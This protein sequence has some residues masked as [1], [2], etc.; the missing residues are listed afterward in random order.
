[1]RSILQ[2]K[3]L[4][5]DTSMDK[6]YKV[7]TVDSED[8]IIQRDIDG[9]EI[10]YEPGDWAYIEYS[11]PSKKEAKK[12]FKESMSSNRYLVKVIKQKECI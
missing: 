1:M 3:R 9:E 2:R 5:G 4:I 12:V 6:I 10:A 8:D 7:I 11:G